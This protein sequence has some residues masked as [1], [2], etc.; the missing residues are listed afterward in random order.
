MYWKNFEINYQQL[1][2]DYLN[3]IPVSE[4]LI[5]FLTE[6]KNLSIYKDQDENFRNILEMGCGVGSFT[7]Y[8][9]KNYQ[10]VTGCDVSVTAINSAKL[11]LKEQVNIKFQSLNASE[12]GSAFKKDSFDLVVDSHLLHHLLDANEREAYFKGLKRIVRPNGLILIETPFLAKNNI[13][14]EKFNLDAGGILW[15]SIGEVKNRDQYWSLKEMDNSYYL[16]KWRLMD[17][18]ALEAEIKRSGLVIKYF[19]VLENNKI[20]P[21][22]DRNYSMLCDPGIVRI[23]ASK[24]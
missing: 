22:K 19:M 7:E 4:S 11:K 23:V 20:I 2:P 5:E 10:N 14:T 17:F 15:E 18:L 24:E 13:F 12:V 1:S 9:G 16:P 3:S 8:L 21:D 6:I